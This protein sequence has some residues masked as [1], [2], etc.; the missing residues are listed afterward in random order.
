MDGE[1]PRH[2]ARKATEMSI[3]EINITSLGFT[4]EFSPWAGDYRDDFAWDAIRDDYNAE[5]AA[6]APEGVSW[7]WSESGPWCT[8]D[9]SVSPDDVHERWTEIHDEQLIDF[10]TI[11]RRHEH[12][13][14]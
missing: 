11:A 4:A 1:T 8:A 10:E 7:G 6:L 13:N 2:T 14:G 5:L 3:R 12:S 9:T